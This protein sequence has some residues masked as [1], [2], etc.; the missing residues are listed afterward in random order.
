MPAFAGRISAIVLAPFLALWAQRARVCPLAFRSVSSSVVVAVLCASRVSFG[1]LLL[2][3]LIVFRALKVNVAAA[4]VVPLLG[5]GLFAVLAGGR[6]VGAPG[7][8][9]CTVTLAEAAWLIVGPGAVVA[10]A[11]TV[12]VRLAVT[13]PRVQL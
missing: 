4:V 11:V 3:S 8:E 5:T 13:P 7:A 12:L 1:V 10:V 6:P 2:P 9:G